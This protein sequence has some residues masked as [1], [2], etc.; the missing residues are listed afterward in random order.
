M[1]I[2]DM[3]GKE[4]LNRKNIQAS[5][6]LSLDL[7]GLNKGLFILQIKSENYSVTEKII[8]N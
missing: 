5:N 1:I 8:I 6:K 2:Y 3:S 4:V 7:N